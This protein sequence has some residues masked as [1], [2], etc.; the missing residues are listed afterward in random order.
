M[1]CSIID[2]LQPL[3]PSIDVLKTSF[4]PYFH[5]TRL[6]CQH[7]HGLNDNEARDDGVG[8]G[9]GVNDVACHTLGIKDLQHGD[10]ETHKLSM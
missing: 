6:T 1:Y 8:G 4:I 9:N 2:H 7:L 10:A 3:I 5:P